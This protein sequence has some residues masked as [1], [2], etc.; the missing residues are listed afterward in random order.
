[1]L[2]QSFLSN[3]KPLSIISLPFFDDRRLERFEERKPSDDVEALM[4]LIPLGEI[5]LSPVDGSY[6]V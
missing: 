6:A 2:F 1:M 5:C 3:P 4:Q